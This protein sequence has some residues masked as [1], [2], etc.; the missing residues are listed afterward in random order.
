MAV[1][2]GDPGELRAGPPAGEDLVPVEWA[3]S[4]ERVLQC[5]MQALDETKVITEDED[6]GLGCRGCRDCLP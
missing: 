4:L 6:V 5:T 1:M 2:G 3:V